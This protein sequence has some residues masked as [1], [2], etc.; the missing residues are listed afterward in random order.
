MD[1]IGAAALTALPLNASA[2][3]YV[4]CNA[5]REAFE[6]EMSLLISE[7][8]ARSQS[9]VRRSVEVCGLPPIP[10]ANEDAALT[11]KS[12]YDTAYTSGVADW[13]VANQQVNT[14]TGMPT[15]SPYAATL[16]RIMEDMRKSG[17]PLPGGGAGKGK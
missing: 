4:E 10:G 17:C 5:M 14:K 13:D 1:A 16:V 12:C 8:R 9:G 2:L 7:R 11:Y 3:D 15:G 6:R